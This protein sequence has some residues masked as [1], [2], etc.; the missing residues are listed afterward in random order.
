MSLLVGSIEQNWPSPET[1]SWVQLR[2][3]VGEL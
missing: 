2:G 3:K 1:N